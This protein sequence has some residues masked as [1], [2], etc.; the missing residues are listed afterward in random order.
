M[1]KPIHGHV[2]ILHGQSIGIEPTYSIKYIRTS[3][4]IRKILRKERIN[5]LKNLKNINKK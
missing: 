3:E 4:S 5:K 2:S 1:N